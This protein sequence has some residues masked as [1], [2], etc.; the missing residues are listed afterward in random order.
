MRSN[1]LKMVFGGFVAGICTTLIAIPALVMVPLA[2]AEDQGRF[3]IPGIFSG[4]GVRMGD[5][6]RTPVL[7][8]D[9]VDRSTGQGAAARL[10]DD[11]HEVVAQLAGSAL[12]VMTSSAEV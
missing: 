3:D 9:S 2:F 1:V 5:A 7:Q 4:A 11:L 12:D 6:C 10:L 8:Q